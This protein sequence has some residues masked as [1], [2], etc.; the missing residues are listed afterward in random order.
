MATNRIGSNNPPALPSTGDAGKAQS[1]GEDLSSKKTTSKLKKDQ[2]SGNFDVDI[3]EKGKEKAL[4]MQKAFEIA[5]NT[6]DIREDKVQKIKDQI[7]N[8]TYQIDSGNIADG[9]L[10][11]AVKEHLAENPD[12]A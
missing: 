10:R 9:I 7:K 8:G 1:I 4:A 6:P 12:I 5:K 3:S 2:I 11:E